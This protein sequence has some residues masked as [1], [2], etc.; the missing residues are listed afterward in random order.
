MR[1]F[2][3]ACALSATLLVA[4]ASCGNGDNKDGSAD[5]VNQPVPMD[6]PATVGGQNLDTLGSQRDSARFR[7]TTL[8]P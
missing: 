7:D 6:T 3:S 4:A 2:I 1:R 5:S 8:R